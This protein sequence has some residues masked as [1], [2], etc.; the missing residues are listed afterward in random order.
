MQRRQLVSGSFDHLYHVL[1]GH[2]FSCRL[3]CFKCMRRL[4]RGS[5]RGFGRRVHG[6]RIWLLLRVGRTKLHGVCFGKLLQQH[7]EYSVRRRQLVSSSCH[8]L[9]ELLRGHVVSCRI[10][11]IYGM[12][13]LRCW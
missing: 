9:H 8:R 11:C 7:G 6:V 3:H 1:R 2:V 4:R 5:I 13:G 12:C 10:S